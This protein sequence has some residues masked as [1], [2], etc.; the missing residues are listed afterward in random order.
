MPLASRANAERL[1]LQKF[2][3]V[4][5]RH[6]ATGGHWLKITFGRMSE[7]ISIRA[8]P[9]S[10]LTHC[11]RSAWST[12]AMVKLIAPRADRRLQVLRWTGDDC[13]AMV[14]DGAH[15]AADRAACLWPN[16]AVS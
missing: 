7:R 13:P 2:A 3:V 9:A 4:A 15:L 10:I 6:N 11:R 8:Q 1:S 12:D 14:M 16:A 5:C